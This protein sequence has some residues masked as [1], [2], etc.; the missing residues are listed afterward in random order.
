MENSIRRKKKQ[1][2]KENKTDEKE[3]PPSRTPMIK[4]N[5]HAIPKKSQ[6]ISN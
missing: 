1:R 2:R 5:P 6:P 3:I 4:D